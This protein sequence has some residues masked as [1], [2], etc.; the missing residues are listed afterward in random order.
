MALWKPAPPTAGRAGTS[1]GWLEGLRKV[2]LPQAITH[3]PPL[4]EDLT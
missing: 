4:S 2:S 1:V 3:L